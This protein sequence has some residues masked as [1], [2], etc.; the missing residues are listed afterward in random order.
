MTEVDGTSRGEMGEPRPIVTEVGGTSVCAACSNVSSR[1]KV[2]F[3]STTR[4]VPPTAASGSSTPILDSAGT[5]LPDDPSENASCTS[6]RGDRDD[7]SR[8]HL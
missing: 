4:S 6:Q 8:W 3:E 2:A 5:D 7:R 1:P